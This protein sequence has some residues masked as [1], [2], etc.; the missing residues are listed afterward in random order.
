MSSSCCTSRV[1]G[2]W[3]FLLGEH[4]WQR[5]LVHQKQL[6]EDCQVVDFVVFDDRRLVTGFVSKRPDS[7]CKVTHAWGQQRGLSQFLNARVQRSFQRRVDLFQTGLKSPPV[8]VAGGSPES[9]DSQ[10]LCFRERSRNGVRQMLRDIGKWSSRRP[11]TY[12][13]SCRRLNGTGV[14]RKLSDSPLCGNSNGATHPAVAGVA[15]R[16][17][18]YFKPSTL[19][20]LNWRSGRNY[21]ERRVVSQAMRTLDRKG[22]H[23]SPL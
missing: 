3:L 16:K 14:I 13:H 10:L 12:P 1:G 8:G 18:L 23:E 17:G 21:G 19:L 6:G 5:E 22:G 9:C 15:R 20:R 7:M 4:P 11:I 2:C